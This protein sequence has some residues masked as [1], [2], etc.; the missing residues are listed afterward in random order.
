MLIPF[1]KLRCLDLTK[2]RAAQIGFGHSHFIP[3][4]RLTSECILAEI[5]TSVIS[6]Q[7]QVAKK[8][9]KNLTHSHP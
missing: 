2:W 4:P 6:S 5:I 7:E 9:E 1:H 3:N 8:A